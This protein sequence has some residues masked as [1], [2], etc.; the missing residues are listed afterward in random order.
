[1][2][3]QSAIKT[4]CNAQCPFE[5]Q[6]LSKVDIETVGDMVQ[7]FWGRATDTPKLPAERFRAIQSLFTTCE[8]MRTEEKPGE[9]RKVTFKIRD[10]FKKPQRICEAAL[11][12]LIGYVFCFS[13]HT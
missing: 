10:K 2:D 6:C 12:F 3:F 5:K 4:G 11:L 9:A 13:I 7:E 1:M 8:A